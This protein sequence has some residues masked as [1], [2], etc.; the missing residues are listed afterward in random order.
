VSAL[1]AYG[2]SKPLRRGPG[3]VPPAPVPPPRRRPCPPPPAV[4]EPAAFVPAPELV[5]V[6]PQRE[7]PGRAPRCPA[8]LYLED[9]VGHLWACQRIT[10]TFRPGFLADTG[11]AS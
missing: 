2:Q 7:E 10:I 11:E 6:D 5:R 1:Y 8:C 3:T 4:P 9:V